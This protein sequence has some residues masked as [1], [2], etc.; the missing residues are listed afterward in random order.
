[1]SSLQYAILL[2]SALNAMLRYILSIVDLRRAR[3]RGG[4]NAP[5]W[6]NKSMYIFYIE[7][8]TGAWVFG[9]WQNAAKRFCVVF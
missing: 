9:M 8:L 4:E 3:A 1:M 6:E 5:P 2:A 7:L